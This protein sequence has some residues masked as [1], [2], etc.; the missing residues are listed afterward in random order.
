MTPNTLDSDNGM[1]TFLMIL[2]DFSPEYHHT[3]FGGNWSTNNGETYDQNS[4][5][6]KQI[7]ASTLA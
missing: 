1:E 5:K 4:L 3:T 6:R 2:R 7:I